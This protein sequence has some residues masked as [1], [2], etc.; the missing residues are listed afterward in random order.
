[1]APACAGGARDLV[2]GRGRGRGGGTRDGEPCRWSP[3][4]GDYGDLERPLRGCGWKVDYIGFGSQI[5]SGPP[6]MAQDAGPLLS[7]AFPTPVQ[8]MGSRGPRA[9]LCLTHPEGPAAIMG[10]DTWQGPHGSLP[11]EGTPDLEPPTGHRRPGLSG[12]A[13]WP[14]SSARPGP[15]DVLDS[16]PG[17]QE[18]DVGLSSL[19]AGASWGVCPSSRRD[20]VAGTTRLGDQIQGPAVSRSPPQPQPHL[21]RSR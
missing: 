3:R 4:S 16:R 6:G 7:V 21:R 12:P 20:R 17:I 5:R 13:C 19:A 11:S 10:P 9:G 14:V 18:A 2:P 8:A 1:M 15:R